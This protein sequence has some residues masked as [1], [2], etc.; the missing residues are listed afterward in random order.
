VGSPALQDEFTAAPPLT[1]VFYNIA[2]LYGEGEAS[3]LHRAGRKEQY[4]AVDSI[5]DCFDSCWGC[6]VGNK[7]LYTDAGYHKED[8][9]RC[10]D[11]CCC[12]LAI[13]CLWSYGFAPQ[14]SYWEVKGL[15]INSRQFLLVKTQAR[16]VFPMHVG[17]MW[18]R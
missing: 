14:Y 5:I 4:Y 17:C 16:K 11:Y 6:F 9:Q 18:G 15:N 1:A 13:E 7:C 3:L 8:P 2:L 10:R 12:D